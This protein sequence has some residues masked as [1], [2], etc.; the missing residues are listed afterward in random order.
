MTGTAVDKARPITMAATL[1]VSLHLERDGP[2]I[3]REPV[4]EADLADALSE[5]WFRT[6]PRRGRPD[7]AFE[8]TH[9]RVL[10]RL[11]RGE[12]S[13]CSGFIVQATDP[14]G[15]T[16]RS[17][18]EIL[19]LE[20][21]ADR[22]ARRLV[23]QGQLQVGDLYY[24]SVYADAELP[25]VAAEPA[26]APAFNISVRKKGFDFL[27]VPLNAVR[28]GARLVRSGSPDDHPVFYTTA[29]L[30]KAEAFARAG[31]RAQPPVETGCVLCGSL[32]ACPETREMF[33]VVYDA[34]EIADAEQHEFSLF[35]SG[36]TWS[37]IQ[38][39]M[40]AR[41]DQ[42]TTRTQ[43][44]VGQAHGH[45]FLPG[46]GADCQSCPD[47]LTCA[48]T[49]AFVSKDDR[50]WTRSVFFRQPW[51]LCHVFGLNARAEPVDT[52]YGLSGGRL[53]RRGYHM[54]DDFNPIQWQQTQEVEERSRHAR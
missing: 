38:A 48:K 5:V 44:I 37:R 22:A 19:A 52:L 53:G 28:G 43:R 11:H 41:Q 9:L 26:D 47:L 32:C 51:A 23:R 40:R 1:T 12:Q 21:V 30:A 27:T 7:I 46:N 18:F 34:L 17:T 13:K 35:Y 6:C 36:K 24:F 14:H 25:A 42:P 16:V 20:H 3:A 54:I 2:E 49:S 45:N 39:V 29:A 4:A 8:E 15:A 50:R 33:C 10:P 31:A